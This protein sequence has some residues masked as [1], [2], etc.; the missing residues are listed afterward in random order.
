MTQEAADAIKNLSISSQNTASLTADIERVARTRKN[1]NVPEEYKKS[2]TKENSNFVVIG[3][4]HFF[5]IF[6][7]SRAALTAVSQG[8][9]MLVKVL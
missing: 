5:S 9:L 1:Y 4:E 3:K 2:L 6:I 7:D 8:M